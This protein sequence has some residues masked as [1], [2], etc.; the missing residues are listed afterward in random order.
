MSKVRLPKELAADDTMLDM[1]EA[2]NAGAELF[3]GIDV[4]GDGRPRPTLPS[5][6]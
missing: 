4:D 3:A 2:A 6:A 5:C 1:R